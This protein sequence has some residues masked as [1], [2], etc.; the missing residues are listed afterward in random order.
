MT[1]QEKIL[2][3]GRAKALRALSLWERGHSLEAIAG[4]IPI[5]AGSVTSTIQRGLRLRDANLS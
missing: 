3:K 1:R 2:H 4:M 5:P